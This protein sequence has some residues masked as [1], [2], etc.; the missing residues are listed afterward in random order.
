MNGSVQKTMYSTAETARQLGVNQ[1]TLRR[2]RVESRG[3]A[4][5]KLGGAIRYRA[6][7]IEA[8]IAANPRDPAVEA[9][10][11]DELKAPDYLKT[12][13]VAA[14]LQLAPSTLKKNARQRGWTSV[15]QVRGCHPLSAIGY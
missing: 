4:Y 9:P 5:V 3:P 12:G 10:M 8:F 2:W 11:A 1:M 7:D 6:A 13:Q 15:L 14:L